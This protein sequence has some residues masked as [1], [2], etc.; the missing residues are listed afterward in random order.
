[1]AFCFRETSAS[2]KGVN[3]IGV[4]S[5]WVTDFG[6]LLRMYLLILAVSSFDDLE[7]FFTSK[8]ASLSEIFD[9]SDVPSSASN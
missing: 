9:S 1:M 5:C 4:V 8:Y 6:M 7:D 2:F 3:G